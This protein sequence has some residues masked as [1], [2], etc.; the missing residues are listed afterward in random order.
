MNPRHAVAAELFGTAVLLMV[1]VGSGIMGETLA[2]GNA[3]IALLGNSIA[4]GAG[5]YVLITVLGP[6]S[7]AHFNPAVSLTFWRTGELTL[8]LFAAYVVAQICGGILGVWLTHA[9][10]DLP[11]LQF[12]TKVRSGIP[13]WISECLATGVLLATIHLGL[14]NAAERVPLLVALIVTAGYWFTAST[15]FANPAVT[16]AR[17]FS[18]TFAGIQPADVAGFIVAQFVACA[19]VCLLLRGSPRDPPR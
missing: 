15:F 18:N 19:A 6:I 17:S 16:I 5:L 8:G 14:R 4:T 10:F 1:V 2:N 9:M 12:S 7:G 11:L 13:Q 3:A